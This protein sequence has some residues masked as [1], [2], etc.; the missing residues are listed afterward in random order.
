MDLVRPSLCET[1]A[2]GARCPA[3]ARR[4]STS[5][6]ANPA[7]LPKMLDEVPGR[8]PVILLQLLGEEPASGSGSRAFGARP[9]ARY[10]GPVLAN[11]I[12]GRWSPAHTGS[13][14]APESDGTAV[15]NSN[16]GQKRSALG[17]DRKTAA[18]TSA[19][20]FRAGE[21]ILRSYSEDFH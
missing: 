18:A 13:K 10:S 2:N 9:G 4:T 16:R 17:P 5:T 15:L 21:A 3:W 19:L 6:K 11:A 8:A 14:D 7:A 12:V 20:H 1:R